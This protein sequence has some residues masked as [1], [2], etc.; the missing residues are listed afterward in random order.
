MQDN[1]LKT[2]HALKEIL[3]RISDEGRISFAEFMEIALYDPVDGYYTT[4]NPIGA[5][6]DYFTS[7]S[8]HPA[9]SAILAIQFEYMWRV[10]GRPQE[11][12]A[13]EMGAGD[14]L[15][16]RDLLDYSERLDPAFTKALKYV[17][18]DKSTNGME[19][20]PVT[21]C[22]ISNELVDAFPVH[23]FQVLEG[24][25]REVFVTVNEKGD[26]VEEIECQKSTLVQSR[27]KNLGYKLPDGFSG[28]VNLAIADWMGTVSKFLKRGF[29][30]TI[31]YGYEAEQLFSP[32]RMEGTIQ[33]YYKHTQGSSPYQRIGSQDITAHVDFS[34]VVEEGRKVGLSPLVLLSQSE[35][36]RSLG[37]GVFENKIRAMQLLASE[38][39]ANLVA[40]RQLTKLEGL[41][42]FAVLVQQKNVGVNT[43]DSLIP[44]AS[45]IE[46][47]MAPLLQDHHIP[48]YSGVTNQVHVA[49]PSF[50]TSPI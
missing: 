28:E 49:S 4:R 16:A 1:A 31:D 10:L 42:G 33:T 37:I 8:A 24:Q 44:D 15:M 46:G 47:L 12:Y 3:R 26:L 5:H 27:L 35:Y 21:G 40:L 41:G 18:I 6:G 14:G 19:N 45:R 38:I 36:L 9:F 2:N 23:R 17:V 39:D 11:F 13:I 50:W 48:L 30:I 34:A 29:V 32:T 22:V 25:P 20:P 7:P 43:Y